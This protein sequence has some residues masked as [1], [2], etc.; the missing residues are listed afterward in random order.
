MGPREHDVGSVDI[1]AQKIQSETSK[2]M[3]RFDTPSG[4]I[5]FNYF[6]FET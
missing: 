2:N 4:P 1:I 3:L 6:S 5:E